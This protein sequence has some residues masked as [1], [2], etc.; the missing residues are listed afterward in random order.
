MDVNSNTQNHIAFGAFVFG[1]QRHSLHT[2]FWT[3]IFFFDRMNKKNETHF[4]ILQKKTVGLS[5]TNL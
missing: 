1:S 3:M 4:A 5:Q 2:V